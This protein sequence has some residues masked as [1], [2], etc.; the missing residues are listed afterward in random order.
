MA[1]NA[2]V[3]PADDAATGEPQTFGG[4]P[5]VYTPG[6][7]VALEAI[8]LDA[9]EAKRLIKEMN[10]PLKLSSG[11]QKAMS[12]GRDVY[13]LGSGDDKVGPGEFTPLPP[14]GAPVASAREGLKPGEQLDEDTEPGGSYS[15]EM[16]D[17]VKEGELLS[18]S[19]VNATVESIENAAGL[20]EDDA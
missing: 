9:K 10:L 14:P 1:E 11:G 7:P 2:L 6:E 16:L 19:E 5:G 8:G 12:E 20:N 3:L 4:F 17:T 15:S 18:A 13:V